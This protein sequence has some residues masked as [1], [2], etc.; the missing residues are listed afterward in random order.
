MVIKSRIFVA[1]FFIASLIALSQCAISRSSKVISA[2]D[3]KHNPN[4][5]EKITNSNG[6]ELVGSA[7]CRSC[8][9]NIYDSFKTTA[10][11]HTS[12]PATAASIKGPFDHV[13]H[14]D[15]T[16]SVYL[17]ST[18]S[19]FYQT[20]IVSED[21]VRK[22]K[23]D[24]TIGSGNKG[25]T[26]LYWKGDSL[27]QL[28]VTYFTSLG[29]WVNSPGLPK[30][31]IVFSRPI[32][33]FCMDCHSTNFKEKTPA[34]FDLNNTTN[35]FNKSQ[36]LFEVGC[37]RCHG[38]GAEHVNFH[39]LNPQE[40]TAKHIVNNRK[41][42][43]KLQLDVCANCHSGVRTPVKPAFSFTAGLKLEDFSKPV[44]QAANEEL[45][46]HGNQ[47]GLMT[48]S[49]CFIKSNTMTCSSC[50]G[51]HQTEKDLKVFSA[52]CMSCHVPEKNFCKLYPEHGNVIKENCIDC[53]MPAKPSQIITLMA[54][55]NQ[56]FNNKIRTHFIKVYPD[57]TKNWLKGY[58]K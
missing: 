27:F 52:K 28:P 53:H 31:E 51:S 45:D 17:S 50:H 58:K 32:N 56:V 20:A 5:V 54:E 40:K 44:Q 35:V 11:Y 26:F 4:S 6:Q 33:S 36:I 37:E 21:T 30:D 24:I 14:Y 34:A 15:Y 9:A 19:G 46:V 42:D 16:R 3:E 25:Q 48:S 10:H 22:E 49:K 43:R 29:E 13:Y 57:E 7:A 1:F 12:Q 47:Y 39:L 18:D 23:F 38:P 41:L 55:G 2:E 8:H